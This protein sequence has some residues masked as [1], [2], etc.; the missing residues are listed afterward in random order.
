MPFGGDD[1]AHE[2]FELGRVVDQLGEQ[3]PEV[4]VEQH[5]ADVEDHA[6]PNHKA[7]AHAKAPPE[8]SDG[9][10]LPC[11]ARTGRTRPG[12]AI[13]PGAPCSGGWSCCSNS[14]GRCRETRDCHGGGPAWTLGRCQF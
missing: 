14:S 11:T 8:A 10:T 9:V 7:P 3:V 5:L 1:M 6:L 4:P 13:S 12:W 2:P